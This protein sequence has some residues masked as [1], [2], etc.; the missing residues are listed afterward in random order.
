VTAAGY[1]ELPPIGEEEFLNEG[2]GSY[3]GLELGNRAFLEEFD[4]IWKPLSGTGKE[5]ERP[6]GEL[7]WMIVDS[8]CRQNIWGAWKDGYYV[9]GKTELPGPDPQWPVRTW[10]ETNCP[11]WQPPP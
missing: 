2:H 10:Y 7:E 4:R 1:G 11:F 8:Y 6:T 3:F 5:L 9:E